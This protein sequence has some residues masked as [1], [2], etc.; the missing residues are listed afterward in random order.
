METFR[1]AAS[2]LKGQFLGKFLEQRRHLIAGIAPAKI[3][4]WECLCSVLQTAS[5]SLLET[6]MP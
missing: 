6:P 1:V 2:Q 5:E 4:L 3:R